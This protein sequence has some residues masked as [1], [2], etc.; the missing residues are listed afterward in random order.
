MDVNGCGEPLLVLFSFLLSPAVLAHR[1]EVLIKLSVLHLY[2]SMVDRSGFR[3]GAGTDFIAA[4][5]SQDAFYAT[6]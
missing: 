3:I 1:Q 4:V 6:R 2:Q 5:V